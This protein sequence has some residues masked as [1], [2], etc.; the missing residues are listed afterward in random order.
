[1]EVLCLNL[2]TKILGSLFR[3]CLRSDSKWNAFN[4]S[5]DF[6]SLSNFII[7][8]PKIQTYFWCHFFSIFRRLVYFSKKLFSTKTLDLNLA[9]ILLTLILT[10]FKFL[11]YIEHFILFLTVKLV[12]TIFN[13]STSVICTDNEIFCLLI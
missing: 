3:F 12:K 10:R 9:I 6:S 1:M 5:Y 13:Y 7:F 11:L 4:W 2:S 8:F